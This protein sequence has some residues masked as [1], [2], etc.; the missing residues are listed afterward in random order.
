MEIHHTYRHV[1]S[2]KLV[3]KKK[4]SAF[5]TLT[6]IFFNK[7]SILIKITRRQTKK[8]RFYLI[9]KIKIVSTHFSD[10]KTS[11]NS[12]SVLSQI[13][14]YETVYLNPRNHMVQVFKPES[15]LID[16]GDLNNTV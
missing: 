9:C 14:Y 16:P 12:W 13:D 2:C 1:F 7:Y 5:Y 11:Y 3:C 6:K 4:K 8:N 10:Y 15:Y